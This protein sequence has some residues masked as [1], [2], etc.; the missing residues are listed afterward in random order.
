MALAEVPTISEAEGGGLFPALLAFQAEAPTL[1]KNATNPHFKSKFTSLDTIVEVVRPLLAKHG[2]V[3]TA[4]PSRDQS[5]EP[6]LRYALTHAASGE[7]ISGTMPLLLTKQDPQGQGSAITY[8]RR[9]SICAVLNLIADE[10]DDGSHASSGT[11]RQAAKP[12]PSAEEL[13]VLAREKA[14][15]MLAAAVNLKAELDPDMEKARIAN[16]SM[17]E[18]SSLY[19]LYCDAVREKGGDPE[20]VAKKFRERSK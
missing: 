13:L 8:A 12:K 7:S 19:T 9:Y 2:L 11:T 20:A 5:G 17:D 14:A 10:D 1:P 3:W 18:L 4:F 16:A 6:A 15:W